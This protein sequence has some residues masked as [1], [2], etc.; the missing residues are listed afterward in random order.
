MGCHGGASVRM[1]D[2]TSNQHRERLYHI[3]GELNLSSLCKQIF[4]KAYNLAKSGQ[5]LIKTFPLPNFKSFL[6]NMEALE[7][8][9]ETVIK[10]QTKTRNNNMFFS[11]LFSEKLFCCSQKWLNQFSLIYLF[12]K[13]S[14]ETNF[15]HG[16]FQ[17]N[18]LAFLKVWQSL[19]QVK[20]VLYWEVK[21]KLTYQQC[22]LLSIEKDCIY[23]YI[24][25]FFNVSDSLSI[26]C[27]TKMQWCFRLNKL[28]SFAR[29]LLWQS[30][31]I[32]MIFLPIQ[33]MKI[34]TT[35]GDLEMKLWYR[36]GL[37]ENQPGNV[38]ACFCFIL[39]IIIVS[40]T[41][42]KIKLLMFHPRFLYFYKVCWKK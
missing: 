24:T 3:H 34:S 12:W 20:M 4:S 15:Q 22:F 16:K 5:L 39:I 40:A 18:W 38:C 14:A 10:K 9:N 21:G 11:Q 35:L 32:H 25:A 1:A 23:I 28:Q 42:G 26:Y 6:Q 8:F 29:R 13:E 30:H 33:L 19:M 17:P 7:L 36:N 37:T 2:A 31:G 41:Q 27:S